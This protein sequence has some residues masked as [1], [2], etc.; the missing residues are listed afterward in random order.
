MH[1]KRVSFG[2]ES[3]VTSK[4]MKYLRLTRIGH[5]TAWTVGL[6]QNETFFI[7]NGVSILS[8]SYF[9]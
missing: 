7:K 8:L 5:D 3:R 4:G 6:R 2:L 1:L 9:E